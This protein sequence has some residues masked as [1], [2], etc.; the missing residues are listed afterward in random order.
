M[1]IIQHLSLVAVSSFVCI[2]HLFECMFPFMQ[3]N[4]V[5]LGLMYTGYN[6]QL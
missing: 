6:K 5:N 1:T 2:C 4:Q 3:Q